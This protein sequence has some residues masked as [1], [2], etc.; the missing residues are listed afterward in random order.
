MNCPRCGSPRLPGL[1]YCGHCGAAL[2]PRDLERERRQVSVLFSDVAGYTSV[3]EALDAEDVREIINEIFARAGGIVANYGDRDSASSGQ[4]FGRTVGVRHPGTARATSPLPST[5]SPRVA[6]S[7][8]VLRTSAMSRS[9]ASRD[10]ASAA[11][12]TLRCTDQRGSTHDAS[13]HDS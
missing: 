11:C 13:S 10:S 7:G 9:G 12:R 1:R 5:S 6:M 2:D 8:G 3:S 4:V